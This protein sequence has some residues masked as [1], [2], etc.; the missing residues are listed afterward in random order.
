M[1]PISDTVRPGYLPHPLPPSRSTGGASRAVNQLPPGGS[2]GPPLFCRGDRS[3]RQAAARHG[4]AGHDGWQ[5]GQAHL[6][7][8]GEFEMAHI[9]RRAALAGTRLDH[10]FGAP[11]ETARQSAG[12]R[13]H[14]TLLVPLNPGRSTFLRFDAFGPGRPLSTLSPVTMGAMPAAGPSPARNTGV[15]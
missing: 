14:G 9:D 15:I 13:R 7:A 3:A 4:L 10:E 2:R 8:I 1:R 5:L 6:S 11:R 12:S